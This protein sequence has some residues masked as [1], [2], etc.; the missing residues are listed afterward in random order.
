MGRTSFPGPSRRIG[1]RPVRSVLLAVVLT[2]LGVACAAPQPQSGVAPVGSTSGAGGVLWSGDLE[3]DDLSQF[4]HAPWNLV[5]GLPPAI[6]TDPVRDGRFALA[7]GIP[8]T[9][10]AR[11]GHLLRLAQRGAPDLPRPGPR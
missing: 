9:Y 6:V 7:L 3:T 1:G 11:C 8:R 5:G 10:D 4:Q 2:V